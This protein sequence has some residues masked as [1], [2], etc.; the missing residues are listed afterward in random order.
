MPPVWLIAML[1]IAWWLG[2][3]MPGLGFGYWAGLGG[4]FLIAGGAVLMGLAVLEFYRAK[5]TIIPGHAPDA[6]ITTGIFQYSR[7]PIYLADTMFLTGL[8]LWWDAVL[9]APL[10][11]LFVWIIRLR[12]IN[13]EEAR[14]Q[15][16]YPTAF[17]AYTNGT[18][19]WL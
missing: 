15:A 2:G 7:N 16:A 12:F 17:A 19:R 14:L 9:A 10:V 18:R 13:H 11:I 1:F 5:T 6:L 3:L 4:M 8:I